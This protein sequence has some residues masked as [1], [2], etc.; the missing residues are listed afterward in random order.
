MLSEYT[1]HHINEIVNGKAIGKSNTPIKQLITDS[2]KAIISDDSM[3]FAIKGQHFDGHVFI[4][5][6]YQK[7]IRHFVISD[8]ANEFYD[9]DDAYFI[10]VDN[11]VDALQKLTRFHRSSFQKPIIGITGSNGKTIV[12]EWLSQIL[13]S[14]FSIAK[15]PKSYNS[16]IGVP[17]SVWRLKAENDFGVFEAGIS[18]YHE[19]EKLEAILHPE[20]G[21]FTNIGSAHAVNFK[22][23]REKILEKLKLF[24]HSKVLIYCKDHTQ[25]HELAQK[26]ARFKT[27]HWSYKEKA[28]ITITELSTHNNR[29]IAKL[30]YL[31][32]NYTFWLPFGD[33][34]SLEN[35]FHAIS[36]A[37]Y[38]GM[39]AN[40]IQ[41]AVEKL[42]P[43][44]MRLELMTGIH[45]STI[46][47]DSYNSDP[48]SFKI[49]LEFLDQQ[50]KHQKKTVILSDILQSGIPEETLY[51]KVNQLLLRHKIN[52][53]VGIGTAIHNNKHLFSET[54]ESTF[55][56]NT[57]AFIKSF[58][59]NDYREESILLKGARVFYFEQICQLLA[60]K[61]HETTLEINLNTLVDNL[62][63]FRHKL[64]PTTKVMAMVKAFSYGSGGFEIAKVLQHH[65]IDY[66]AVAYSDEGIH[67][68]ESGITVPI[69]V[70][71]ASIHHFESIIDYELEPEIYSIQHLKHLCALLEKRQIKNYPIHI[72]LDTGMHRLGFEAH[73]LDDLILYLDQQQTIT[74][75]S[76]FTHLMSSDQ[77]AHESITQ[78][79][80][81]RF[82]A[83][84]EKIEKVYQQ[85][86]V[87]HVL[88][89]AG[90][91]SYPERQYDMVRLGI[92][93]Y[94]VSST[95][96]DQKNLKDI[97]HLK[98]VISQIKHI[99]KGDFVGYAQ[100]FQA[101]KDMKIATVNIG[102]ADG[103]DKRFE[104]GAFSMLYKNQELPIVGNI[105]MDMCMLDIS[106]ADISEGD[107]VSVFGPER[108][109]K[110][111]AAYANI[112]PYEMLT[113]I[114]TRVKRIYV[115]E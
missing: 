101:K 61:I 8:L 15:N 21:V 26:E 19:M 113:G 108:S 40:Q 73:E 68:K 92:G 3:Y 97:G 81:H 90:I 111:V 98:A 107:I 104:N 49:A 100:A 89:S 32:Q 44:A 59:R 114:S 55:F 85:P 65:R 99:K 63:Y 83:M 69:M 4:N 36:T 17:L 94:G 96:E 42:S 82:D 48:D 52:R 54:L 93:L 1:A 24:T 6:L 56:E 46:I 109:I 115:Q 47:N 28:A 71:N 5:E 60:S 2:R 25:I 50:S 103:L 77:A 30:V 86:F 29:S 105:C 64:A 16:Q 33:K 84:C 13:S 45:N 87:K 43:V 7:G 35:C 62:H 23:E 20:I 34:S 58:Q 38:C 72:K 112:S 110:E 102:Y 11:V 78:D 10:Q 41:K 66:L 27:L 91:A 79:Q 95:E 74:I 88:N 9:L 57:T 14:R 22:N 70:L 31:G 76:V 53:F 18:E 75:Q 106:D 39:N 67:L 12:K 51:K 80:F 37:F